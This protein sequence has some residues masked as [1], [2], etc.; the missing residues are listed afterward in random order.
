MAIETFERA[1]L[2]M[3]MAA[4][5]DDNARCQKLAQRQEV[6]LLAG[7]NDGHRFFE[8]KDREAK[9]GER[10]PYKSRG[11]R[12]KINQNIFVSNKEREENEG[13]FTTTLG[14][15]MPIKL[16]EYYRFV[17]RDN[18]PEDWRNNF[19]QSEDIGN[20]ATHSSSFL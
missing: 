12:K 16:D 5:A 13:H 9:T 10:G 11:L 4:I 20:M 7:C 14:Y 2:K 8:E 6:S 18:V 1:Q 3:M 19:T 15:L 17:L